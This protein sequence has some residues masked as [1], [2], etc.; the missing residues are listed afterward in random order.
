[1]QNLALVLA[2][3]VLT[4]W[5]AGVIHPA[6]VG[7]RGMKRAHVGAWG[8]GAT[9]IAVALAKAAPTGVWDISDVTAGLIILSLLVGWPVLA[10]VKVIRDALASRRTLKATAGAPVS[11]AQPVAMDAEPA[12][13]PMP[14]RSNKAT[15]TLRSEPDQKPISKAI[16]HEPSKTSRWAIDTGWRRGRVSFEY[17]DA[18]GDWSMR[19]VTVHSVSSTRIQGECHTRR[20]ER[21]FLL[22]RI[23]GDIVDLDTGEILRPRE[24]ARQYA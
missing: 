4:A 10:V 20:A 7:L 19:T 23:Q 24:L 6:A 1:M 14:E 22:E 8:F 3:A 11:G 9:L 21:T 5:C 15:P 18:N 17:V 12:H 2:V 13:K 16:P